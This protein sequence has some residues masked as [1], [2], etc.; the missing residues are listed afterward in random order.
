MIF[1]LNIGMSVFN[2]WLKNRENIIT[3]TSR[4][5]KD[6]IVEILDPISLGLGAAGLAG[7]GTALY[8]GLNPRSKSRRTLSKWREDPRSTW[9][10]DAPITRQDAY[11]KVEND[12]TVDDFAVN[13]GLG[14]VPVG[15]LRNSLA[16]IAVARI[17]GVEF[18]SIDEPEL[19]HVWTALQR[20][21]KSGQTLAQA[22]GIFR[23]RSIIGKVP[24]HNSGKKYGITQDAADYDVEVYKQT[25]NQPQ[26][27]AAPS[28]SPPSPSGTAPATAPAA[29]TPEQQKVIDSLGLNSHVASQVV[30]T[31]VG[32]RATIKGPGSVKTKT[33]LNNIIRALGGTP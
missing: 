21:S 13:L 12:G 9:N 24:G 10:R 1:G 20:K 32:L 11:D 17:Y 5:D 25:L 27:A 33:I 7:V 30:N 8:Q 14:S 23:P 22:S 18:G 3:G 2:K 19:A 16:R 26:P 29:L 31:L 6:A 28:T 15:P 4:L